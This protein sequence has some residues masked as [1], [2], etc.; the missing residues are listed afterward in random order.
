MDLLSA[1]TV[2]LDTTLTVLCLAQ[3]VML[4]LPVPILMQQAAMIV[5]YVR[6]GRMQLQDHHSVLHVMLDGMQHQLD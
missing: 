5:K 6:L 1:L 4:E 3:L 2:G